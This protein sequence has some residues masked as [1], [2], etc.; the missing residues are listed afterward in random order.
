M[1]PSPSLALVLLGGDEEDLARWSAAAPGAECQRAPDAAAGY[2]A[3]TAEVIVF[4]DAACLPLPGWQTRWCAA[5]ADP[6]RAAAAGRVFPALDPRC[7]D[8]ARVV[9]HENSG[10]FGR[11]DLGHFDREVVFG[12]RGFLPVDHYAVRRSALDACGGWPADGAPLRRL[13]EAGRGVGYLPGAAVRRPVAADFPLA[14][15]FEVAWREHGRREVRM[16]A[17]RGALARRIAA[18]RAGRRAARYRRAA[19]GLEPRSKAWTG[20]CAKAAL[21]EGRTAELRRR[22]Q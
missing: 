16:T 4:L 10:P 12:D 8:W 14:E 9:Q 17:P 6:R 19:A 15:R 20:I 3:S 22:P 1:S 13:L 7:E 2:A 11:F 21:H 18:W 5:F